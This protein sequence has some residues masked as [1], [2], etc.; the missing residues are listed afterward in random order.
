MKKSEQLKQQIEG[1]QK[2]V[3]T[4]ILPKSNELFEHVKDFHQT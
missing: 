2:I 1:T 4:E 3:N